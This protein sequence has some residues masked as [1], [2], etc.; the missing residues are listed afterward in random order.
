[1]NNNFYKYSTDDIN[2]KFAVPDG[3]HTDPKYIDYVKPGGEGE[4]AKDHNN[5]F[6]KNTLSELF[7]NKGFKSYLIEFWD[8]KGCF[9]QGYEDEENGIITRSFINDERNSNGKPVYTSLIIDFKKH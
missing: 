7:I 9:H 2:I 6:N 1:M 8:E 5:L 4:G 3:F